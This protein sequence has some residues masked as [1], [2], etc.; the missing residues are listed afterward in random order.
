MRFR[1][2]N[3]TRTSH[4]PAPALRAAR[5]VDGRL[6]AVRTGGRP[7]RMPRA[8]RATDHQPVRH[9]VRHWIRFHCADSLSLVGHDVQ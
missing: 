4:R 1:I 3:A 5:P 7:R 2:P 9:R 8:A 6:D